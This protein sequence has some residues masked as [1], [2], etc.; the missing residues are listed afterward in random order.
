MRSFGPYGTG[1]EFPFELSAFSGQIIGFYGRSGWYLDA[2]GVYVKVCNKIIIIDNKHLYF[3]CCKI[4]M[5]S[6]NRQFHKIFYIIKMLNKI[7]LQI[8]KQNIILGPKYRSY[9]API[10]FPLIHFHLVLS[11]RKCIS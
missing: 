10:L 9:H 4:H 6:S 5:K 2:L 7:H 8:C 3:I 11:N 1:G